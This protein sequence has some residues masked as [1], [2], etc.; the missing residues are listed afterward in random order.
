MPYKE[1]LDCLERGNAPPTVLHPLYMHG[2]HT[3]KDCEQWYVDCI[4]QD[5][6][7]P[8]SA[9]GG[10]PNRLNEDKHSK[11]LQTP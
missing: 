9:L 2:A 8:I 3:A 4:L 6:P 1:V 5:R 7:V 11:N 10:L